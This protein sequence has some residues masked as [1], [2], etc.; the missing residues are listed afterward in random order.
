MSYQDKYL[1]YKNKYIQLKKYLG[2]A[3]TVQDNI[4]NCT[5]FGTKNITNH[6]DCIYCPFNNAGH[7]DTQNSCKPIAGNVDKCLSNKDTIIG[8]RMDLNKYLNN[9]STFTIENN[10]NITSPNGEVCF[11]NT[12]TTCLTYC[13]ILND[14]TKISVH[15]NP[16]TTVFAL[17]EDNKSVLNNETVNIINSHEKI[18]QKLV[19][20]TSKDIKIK[21]IILLGAKEYNVYENEDTKIISDE[22]ISFVDKLK[23]KLSDITIKDFLFTFFKKYITKDTVYVEK[24]N[25]EIDASK[26]YMI[27]SDG[28][29]IILDSNN[30]LIDKF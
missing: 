24:F 5:E 3:R 23:Y 26:I 13:F 4:R 7:N 8:N 9:A 30:K 19:N 21:K 16:A 12:I 1:K 25:I 10:I 28:T 27:R 22:Y 15:I 2:G 11:G 6:A 14:N 20:M 17:I 29:G 18:L